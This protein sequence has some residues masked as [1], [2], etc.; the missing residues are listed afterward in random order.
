MKPNDSRAPRDDEIDRLLARQYHDT[1]PEFEA[2][3][4]ALKRELRS[5]PAPRRWPSWSVWIG[6]FATGAVAALVLT[7]STT[8][9]MRVPSAPPGVDAPVM[10]ELLAMDDV[11]GRGRALLN[12]E[13]RDALLHLST[14]AQPRN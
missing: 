11:L 7:L 13:D 4:V 5:A 8:R 10:A 14:Q 1:T 2:R 3:W 12:A 6:L 9:R